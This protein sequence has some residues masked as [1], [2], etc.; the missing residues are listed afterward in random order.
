MTELRWPLP[1]CPFIPG[2]SEKPAASPA[3][4]AAAAAP[5]RTDPDRWRDNHSYVYAVALHNAGCFWEAHEVLEAVWMACP[6][7]SRARR[8]CQ[9]LIQL[10]NACLKLKMGRSRA[11]QRLLAIAATHWDG[12]GPDRFMGVEIASV[13]ADIS[14]LRSHVAALTEPEGEPGAVSI[15]II[16][17]HYIA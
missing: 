16:N 17:L 11:C 15:P 1:E 14:A 10:S 8:H 9:A 13:L 7:N 5:D 3:F 6:P 2:Q 4:E 12:P